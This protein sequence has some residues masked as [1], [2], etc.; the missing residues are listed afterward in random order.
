M[1]LNGK[2]LVAVAMVLGAVATTGCK[3]GEQ[4]AQPESTTPVVEQPAQSIAPAV[5]DEAVS[6]VA[7]S[8]VRLAAPPALRVEVQGRAPSTHHTWQR[9]YWRY[10]GPSTRYVWA[11][12][13]WEDTAVFAPFGPPAVRYEDPGYAPGD[14]YLFVPGSWRWSGR[15]YVWTYGH[16][17]ARRDVG[18]YYRPRW[19]NVNGHW[20][21]RMDRWDNDRLSSWDRNHRDQGH[22]E[23]GHFGQ[24]HGEQ[25]HA[26]QGHGNQ[27]HGDQGHTGQGQGHGDQ[28]HTG[29][30]HTDQ[31]H[32]GQGHADQGQAGQVPS[33]PQQHAAQPMV[34]ATR[35]TPAA[36]TRPS[37]VVATRPTPVV[38]SRQLAPHAASP[39]RHGRG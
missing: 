19:E 23:Q 35:P 26:D 21:H 37:P 15:E 7:S 17:T 12:G 29:Q 4:A 13:Y 27:S 20:E 14:D 2:I 32:T 33:K 38:A 8:T 18:F 5:K 6:V 39:I 11:P 9:G 34:E 25:G 31:G 16:W 24:G 30:G 22:G 3:S 28:G 36:A 1:N 10:D